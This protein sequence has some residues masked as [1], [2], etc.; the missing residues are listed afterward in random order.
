MEGAGVS[1]GSEAEQTPQPGWGAGSG[2][3]DPPPPSRASPPGAYLVGRAG[4]LR[5][6]GAGP[7]DR[8][9]AAAAAGRGSAPQ[10]GQGRRGLHCSGEPRRSRPRHL[11]RTGAGAAAGLRRAAPGAGTWPGP[12]PAPPARR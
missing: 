12:G 4:A 3:R 2:Q 9:A 6:G 1:R 8:A 11:L 7:W 5:A 10:P